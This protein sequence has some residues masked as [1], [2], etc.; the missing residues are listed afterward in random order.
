MAEQLLWGLLATHIVY[1]LFANSRSKSEHPQGLARTIHVLLQA[2]LLWVSVYI[3]IH[4]GEFSRE[5][6]SPVYIVAGL[7]AGHLIFGFSIL[8]THLSWRDAWA[9]F[10]D[11]GPLWNFTMDSPVVLTRF[12][13]V[14]FAEELIWRVAAQTLAIEFLSQYMSNTA[15]AALGIV[16]IAAGFVVV[17]KHFFENTWYIS[18]EFVAFALLIG[19]LYYWTGSFI[20]VII[21]HALRDIEIAYLEYLG[22]VEELGSEAEAA[23]AIEQAYR[24]RRMENT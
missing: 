21:I 15:A 9:H 16:L 11:F 3:G 10:F 23:L 13:G 12:F 4:A 7:L 8:L 14:A 22:K 24:P 1:S 20:L 18:V 2:P 6:V 5:L 19:A 17:H